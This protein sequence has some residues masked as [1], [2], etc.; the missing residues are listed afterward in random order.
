MPSIDV[1][2]INSLIELI[3]ELISQNTEQDADLSSSK[4]YMKNTLRFVSIKQ[5]EGKLSDVTF[6]YD[7]DEK[8]N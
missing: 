4:I 1:L 2:S 3:F 7:Y 5:K 6:S 8:L